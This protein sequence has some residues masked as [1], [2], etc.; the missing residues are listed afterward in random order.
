M[1]VT[2]SC[3]HCGGALGAEDRYCAQCGAEL[4]TCAVCGAPRLP[5]DLSCPACGKPCDPVDPSDPFSLD[6]D[7]PQSP[8]AEMVERLRRAALGEFEIGRELGRGG[9]AAVFLAHEISLDRK[10]AIKLISPGLLLGEGMVDRFRH[11]AITIAQLHHPNIVP[12]Y[13]VRHTEGLHFFVM[14]YVRGASLEQVIRRSGA[15]PL[16]IVRSILH[17][18]GS[19]LT[20]AHRCR[21][22]HRDIKPANILIDEDGNAIVTDFGIAKAA[23][24]P[25]QTL[26]GAV[27]GTPAYM[28]PEQC[29]GSEVSG[30]SDQYALGA[31]A[32]EM[33]TGTPPFSG[34]TTLTIMQAHL[35]QPPPALRERFADCPP[36]LETAILRMLA[37]DPAARWP[38]MGEAMAARGAAPLADDDPLRAELSRLAVGDGPDASDEP[39][40][41]SPAPLTKPSAAAGAASGRAVGRI[42]I[43]PPPA[44]FEVGDSFELIAMLSGRHGSRLPSSSVAWTS[45]APEVLRVENGGATAIA[46]AAGSAQITATCKGVSAGLRVEVASPRGDEIV[47]GPLTRAVGVGDEIPL[48]AVACDKRGRPVDRAVTWQSDDPSVISVTPGGALLARQTGFTRLTA[49][50][51][52]ARA[53]IVIPVL[54]ARVTAIRIADAPATLVAGNTLLL[55]ATPVDRW[56]G[57]LADRPILWSSSD[58][59]VAV[60]TAGGW[61]H[62]L[63][64]GPV[65][66][67]ATCEGVSESVRLTVGVP[68]PPAAVVPEPRAAKHRRPRRHRRWRRALLA[69][70]G[71]AVAGGVVWSLRRQ[72]AASDSAAVREPAA[73]EPL[74][75][76]D[77]AAPASVAIVRK[78]GRALYPDSSTRLVAEVRDL[79]GRPVPGAGVVWRSGDPKVVRVDSSTGRARAL[80]PGRTQVLASSG[81]WRDSAWLVVRPPLRAA[82]S[83]AIDAGDPVR[84][85]ET[86]T[87]TATVRDDKGDTLPGAE[88]TWRSSNV[89]IAAVNPRTG[90]VQGVS[91]GTVL[92]LAESGSESVFAELTVLPAG[93][94]ETTTAAPVDTAA[95]EQ[96][97]LAGV[98]D[99]YRAVQSRDLDHLAELYHPVTDA[100]ADKLKRLSRILRAKESSADVGRRVD[101]DRQIGDQ[102]AAMEF[103][104]QLTWYDEAGGRLSSQP[105][106]RA[107]FAGSGSRW[108]MSSCR[109]VGAPQ[110]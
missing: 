106:F 58:I 56:G 109:I 42:A 65:V 87:L 6:P 53:S 70:A 92:I 32:Y 77:S 5:T 104:F 98:G 18:V 76:T 55:T 83:I 27:V 103:S 13:S 50:L 21:V 45:D 93:N 74:T 108:R 31:V 15:L 23:E 101:G 24:T 94:A 63:R 86:A 51:D 36:E 64:S 57:P 41:T 44:G 69:V 107:E 85:G 20:Y 105:L 25:I 48:D 96:R 82:A 35:D 16:P 12:V 11:E 72:P 78:P 17:Q 81:A 89:A 73:A 84:V 40:P 79:S 22:I 10:V 29:R 54:P 95:I 46:L 68:D 28:S 19:A 38:R 99:C 110:F 14:R 88:V 91:A 75:V 61:V 33:V 1:A 3:A 102:I 52:D 2:L 49:L 4:L 34:S 66:L 30:A 67:T 37:K 100:D 62:T 59:K 39:T 80:R 60:V 9:M 43:L 97:M 90:R 8:W 47:L 7:P 26:S 71:A